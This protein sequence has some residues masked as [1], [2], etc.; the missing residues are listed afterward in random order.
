V[1]MRS[2]CARCGASVPPEDLDVRGLH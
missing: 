2:S 1:L